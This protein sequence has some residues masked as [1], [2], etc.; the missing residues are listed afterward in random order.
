M[1]FMFVLEVATLTGVICLGLGLVRLRARLAR[2]A[3]EAERRQAEI[4]GILLAAGYLSGNAPGPDPPDPDA[5]R[6]PWQDDDTHDGMRDPF[7]DPE[8]SRA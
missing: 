3:G 4:V 2:D 1:D 7:L 8:G 5:P 6:D